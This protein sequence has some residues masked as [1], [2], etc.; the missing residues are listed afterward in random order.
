MTESD[1]DRR[2]AGLLFK[3]VARGI[4][5][6]GTATGCTADSTSQG[7]RELRQTVATINRM[8]AAVQATPAPCT[9]NSDIN[10]PGGVLGR[11]IE[12]RALRNEFLNIV[13]IEAYSD[14]LPIRLRG[15]Q[16]T[17]QIGNTTTFGPQNL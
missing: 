4:D 15:T 5:N 10:V 3:A 16:A 6:Y 12:I 13:G 2:L 8:S 11:Y 9:T 17:P 1:E 7:C 14:T